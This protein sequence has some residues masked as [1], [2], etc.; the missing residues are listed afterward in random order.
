[1]N[2]RI[3][4]VVL[5]LLAGM[6]LKSAAQ[7]TAFSY[8]G[9]L[10][11]TGAPANA[12]Y[13][14]RFAVYDAGTN[15]NQ[16][17]LP[18]TNSAVA[19]SNGLFTVTLDF[20]PDI[21]TGASRWLDIAVRA[22][23]GTNF[24][25]LAPRQPVLPVPYAI[26]STGASNLLG[27]VAA[28]Q[29]T[30]TVPSSQIAGTYSNPV[31]FTNGGNSFAGA[32]AGNGAALTNLSATQLT[33]GTV[34][35]ARLSA[36]V[37][38][39]TAN[40]TFTG[41]NNFTGANSFNGA[42]SFTNRANNF[43]GSFF[44]NGLVGWI[45]VSGP[46]VQA[47]PDTGYMLTGSQLTTVTMPATP[48]PVDIVRISG[49][50]PGGWLAVANSGQSFIGNFFSYRNSLWQA[51]SVSGKCAS[52]AASADGTQ[53]YAAGSYAIMASLDSG[54]TWISAIGGFSGTWNGIATSADGNTVIAVGATKP[55]EIS[56]NA[57]KSWL[58]VPSTSASNCVAIACSA[59]GTK[60][61]AAV[62]SGSVY[63]NNA[64]GIWSATGSGSAGNWVAVACAGSG[65]NRAAANNNGTVYTT[66]G[67]S[68][69][70]T[71]S[72]NLTAL[73]V[74]TDGSKLVTCA[75]PGGIYTSTNSGASWVPTGA[76]TTNWTCLAAS[77]D[78]TRLVA[79]VSN[80]FIY[81]SANFGANW[82]L[83]TGSTN[84]AWSA[85]GA[86]A[87]GSRLVGGTS[88]GTG[89][90]IFYSTANLLSTTSTNATI[91][92]S[93]GSAVELQYLG[94]GQF[95]PVSSAGTLWVN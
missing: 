4:L 1:M 47:L 51:T 9:R 65:N 15:G 88:P 55:I 40:Q 23:G 68:A 60:S 90:T 77:A 84:Q 43:T 54:H 74:S 18:V 28:S 10:N 16:I 45:P 72:P 46:A 11:D 33:A 86:S 19:V 22:A 30:G 25:T 89:G 17:S 48:L 62:K 69:T 87:D 8:Q 61:V 2:R 24:T 37:P 82:T 32:F 20:G 79:G 36:N 49:A 35:D 91:T 81:A 53:M 31:N 3:Q 58:P 6:A 56:L 75:S 92:G 12:A 21:F 76:P 42:N 41:A 27:T 94:N 71:G 38:L 26:F 44:G 52:L 83:L 78:C 34:A 80:G 50:G 14:F 67:G 73:A 93:Q 29:L 70:V 5:L 95:M 85:L 57:G 13:D 66:V 63:T 59:D 7:G 64:S 39:L